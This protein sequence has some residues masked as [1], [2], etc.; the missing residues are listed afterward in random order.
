MTSQSGSIITLDSTS[1]V[2]RELEE[3]QS[4]DLTQS[5]S[6][7]PASN[8]PNINNLVFSAAQVLPVDQA[9][10]S[11]MEVESKDNQ[12]M[13]V[14][15]VDDIQ[16]MSLVKP[17]K[18]QKNSMVGVDNIQDMSL[19]KAKDN[20]NISVVGVKDDQNGSICKMFLKRSFDA[21]T[22]I[23]NKTFNVIKD[24][25]KNQPGIIYM[26]LFMMM[27]G[28]CRAAPIQD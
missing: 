13:S 18:S 2:K 14:A 10:L 8:N 9:Q 22:D 24:I 26:V 1:V 3:A 16:D 17:K 4:E 21:F 7:L 6:S 15:G 12:D 25:L 11:N 27:I 19:V 5:N 23:S 28:V 20:Q